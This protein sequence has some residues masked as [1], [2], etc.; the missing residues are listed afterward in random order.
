MAYLDVLKQYRAALAP[1][2]KEQ[3]EQRRRLETAM[4]GL[5]ARVGGEY[6]IPRMAGKAF[7]ERDV[8]MA[9]LKGA[10]RGKEEAL[11]TT[12]P[13]MRAEYTKQPGEE[14][15][16]NP[17]RVESVIRAAEEGRQRE[18]G[19]LED[20]MAQRF[21]TRQDAIKDV[22]AAYQAGTAR[23]Q[24]EV[25][26]R[27]QML[28][29]STEDLAGQQR[30]VTAAYAQGYQEELEKT[31]QEEWETQQK[32]AHQTLQET[33]AS[34]QA[35]ETWEREKWPTTREYYEALTAQALRPPTGPQPSQWQEQRDILAGGGAS[36]LADYASRLAKAAKPGALT[37]ATAGGQPAT[38]QDFA[39]LLRRSVARD[40]PSLMGDFEAYVAQYAPEGGSLQEKIDYLV[41]IGYSEEQARQFA[42]NIEL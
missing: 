18:I 20:I 27:Q 25:T 30:L 22:I 10:Q 11:Y 8:Q 1:Y 17:Y 41:S 19:S 31:R 4:T 14:G 12:R 9:G 5:T 33:I 2:E 28:G 39:A 32:L 37:G 36:V 15:Y 40:Y 3:A 42:P 7:R 26:S 24:A 35:T 13:T 21:G 38:Y 29:Y 6:T 23:A 16:I 34:R